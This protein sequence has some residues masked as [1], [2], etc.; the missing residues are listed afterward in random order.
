MQCV[1]NLTLALSSYETPVWSSFI[2]AETLYLGVRGASYCNAEPA[3]HSESTSEFFVNL[4][5]NEKISTATIQGHQSNVLAS[6]FPIS[7]AIIYY[8]ILH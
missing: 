8:S 6:Q 7:N 2:L 3:G 4:Q 1:V 5:R